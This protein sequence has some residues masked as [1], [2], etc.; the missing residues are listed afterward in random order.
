MTTRTDKRPK[1]LQLDTSKFKIPTESLNSSVNNTPK[2]SKTG[3]R[4]KEEV[5]EEPA[6]DYYEMDLPQVNFI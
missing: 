1:N 5:V 3:V 2:K 4:L 6:P